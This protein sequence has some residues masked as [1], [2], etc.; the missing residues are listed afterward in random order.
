M[1]RRWLLVFTYD[2]LLTDG[3]LP[4]TF[5]QPQKR[6][7]Y[8]YYIPEDKRMSGQRDVEVVTLHEIQQ[9]YTLLTATL[10]LWRRDPTSIQSS[11][12]SPPSCIKTPNQ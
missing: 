6:Q 3:Y 12:R 5:M 10:A 11:G 1:S 2:F 8:S 4:N 9:E 7:K